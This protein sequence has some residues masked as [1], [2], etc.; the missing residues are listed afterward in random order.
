MIDSTTTR[1][2][3]V[4]HGE[5]EWNLIGKQQGQLDISLTERGVQQ[6]R[7]L[8]EGMIGRGVER[9][10]SS[11]L[12]RASSTADIIS[13]RLGLSVETDA[14]LRE[15]H[16]GSL[17][18]MTKEAWRKQYPDE[19]TAFDSGDP[20][21]RF[22]GGESARER[23]ER[24]VGCVERIVARNPGRTILIV[25]HGGVLNGLFYRAIG[26][27]LSELR[28]FSLFNA[29]INQFTVSDNTWGLD[30]WGE[31]SHLK[32]LETLDDN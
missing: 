32:G 23:Y 13:A 7:A 27:P 25:T 9:I 21:Y 19:W 12:G 10:F 20:D 30:T 3:A 24:T 11:D 31:M 14:G 16:L 1:I 18:G 26:I 17:Q 2:Y 28:R 29:A 15:R 8:A 5:T 6:A 4:R 22:P